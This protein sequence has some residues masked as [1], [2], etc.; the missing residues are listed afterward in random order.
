MP[1][2]TKPAAER[3]YGRCLAL[4]MGRRCENASR[5]GFGTCY[6][7]RHQEGVV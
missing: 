2:T 3:A 1:H 5:K 4:V 7:H 6:S